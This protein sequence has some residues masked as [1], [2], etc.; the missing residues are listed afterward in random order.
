MNA[1]ACVRARLQSCRTHTI[2][3]GA[4][5]W[6]RRNPTLKVVSFRARRGICCSPLI[7]A[8][9]RRPACQGT[10]SVVPNANSSNL[11]IPSE[12][13]P[14]VGDTESKD[15]YKLDC[16][17][18]VHRHLAATHQCEDARRSAFSHHSSRV[19]TTEGRP[20]LQCWGKGRYLILLP[21][22]SA[23]RNLLFAIDHRSTTVECPFYA[24]PPTKTPTPACL[25]LPLTPAATR[26]W[27]RGRHPD[28]PGVTQQS[29]SPPATP[30]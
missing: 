27:A 2:F 13:S 10:T 14:D 20:A 11:V 16:L 23:A 4:W 1:D 7:N 30:G 8:D 24:P 26:A 18:S 5:L 22:P 6:P 9:E 25:L 3:D 12:V 21:I 28:T 15:P 29:I 19:A 17:T